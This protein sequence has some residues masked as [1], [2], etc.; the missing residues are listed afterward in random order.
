MFKDD[1]HRTQIIFI[2]QLWDDNH[3]KNMRMMKRNIVHLKY[4]MM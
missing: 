2:C 1:Y 3:L 4:L